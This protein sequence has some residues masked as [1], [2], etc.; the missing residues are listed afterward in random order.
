MSSWKRKCILM[1]GLCLLLLP[2]AFFAVRHKQ[3][4]E[5]GVIDVHHARPEEAAPTPPA[6]S[7]H[8]AVPAQDAVCHA[9]D[10][11]H[12]RH[13]PPMPPPD[14]RIIIDPRVEAIVSTTNRLDARL[15]AVISLNA[16]S[17]VLSFKEDISALLDVLLDSGEDDTLRHET[18]NLLQRQG[19][20]RLLPALAQIALDPDDSER[21]RGFCVQHL[22]RYGAHATADELVFLRETMHS[23]L[24]DPAPAVKREAMLALLREGDPAGRAAAEAWLA[25][26]DMYDLHDLAI[27]GIRELD[28]REY[29]PRI[30]TAVGSE[31]E[32]V[33]IA[34]IYT[35]AEWNDTES[36][37]AIEAALE[38]ES[39]R[40]RR[41]AAAALERLRMPPQSNAAGKGLPPSK[42]YGI[43][44]AFCHGGRQ[45]FAADGFFDRAFYRHSNLI[46]ELHA[47]STGG[48]T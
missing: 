7:G 18:A 8:R 4:G 28:L 27:R 44:T 9:P 26:D 36:I 29:L 22:W 3:Y 10:C 2:M 47:V 45:S 20:E 34:A 35:A 5:S 32:P 46:H 37:P 6:F 19:D 17:V 38:A 41:A 24:N 14:Q 43:R 42:T 11:K 21:F 30:R 23:A 15:S 25:D 31:Y 1:L 16:D 13:S 39:P 12:E 48:R 40:V 33:C